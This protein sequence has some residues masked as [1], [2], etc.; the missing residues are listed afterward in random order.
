MLWYLYYC[1]IAFTNYK[2]AY[3]NLPFILFFFTGQLSSMSTPQRKI[4]QDI[5][6]RVI[7]GFRFDFSGSQVTY[8]KHLSQG[9]WRYFELVKSNFIK[10]RWII[11]NKCDN[12]SQPC[13]SNSNTHRF[14]GIFRCQYYTVWR[15]FKMCPL[16]NF[17]IFTCILTKNTDLNFFTLKIS[18]SCLW[19]FK[20]K[21]QNMESEWLLQMV[22]CRAVLICTVCIG[23]VMGIQMKG[24]D[25]MNIIPIHPWQM[26]I[27]IA[28]LFL[29]G[30]AGSNKATLS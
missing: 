24:T 17:E 5:L 13:L 29:G 11:T 10:T 16:N 22:G 30:K 2:N 3:W 26:V 18:I 21:S 14:A 28:L 15:S 20:E 25:G 1:W 9:F 4:L 8:C 23:I 7:G 19:P 27:K 6:V 12:T